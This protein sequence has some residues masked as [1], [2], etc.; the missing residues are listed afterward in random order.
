MDVREKLREHLK[1]LDLFVVESLYERLKKHKH[2]DLV[3]DWE[4]EVMEEVIRGKKAK[5]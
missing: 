5:G 4:Y 1:A 3:P 2:R